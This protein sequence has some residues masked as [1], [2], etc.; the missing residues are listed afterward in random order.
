MAAKGTEAKENLMKVLIEANKDNYVGCFDKKYYFW[1]TEGG[2]KVQVCLS[3]TC[4][5]V[6]VG[7]EVA[8]PVSGS[9]HFSWG[10]ESAASAST[11]AEA[12]VGNQI[13]KEEQ[14][15]IADLM[16]RLGL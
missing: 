6:P 2:E 11:V 13:T 4:P 5:K 14:Q 7:E 1:S 16:A 15:N 3:L 12:G 8:V 9:S 10:E